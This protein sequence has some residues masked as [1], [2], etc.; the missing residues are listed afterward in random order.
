[1]NQEEGKVRMLAEPTSWPVRDQGLV[2]QRPCKSLR[3]ETAPHTQA[4]LIHKEA[5]QGELGWPGGC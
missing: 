1:M 4:P 2:D 3:C 5:S